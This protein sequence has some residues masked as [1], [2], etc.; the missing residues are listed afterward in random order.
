MRKIIFI[1]LYFSFGCALSLGQKDPIAIEHPE[2]LKLYCVGGENVWSK[3][4][5]REN[6]LLTQFTTGEDFEPDAEPFL[7]P[8]VI[9]SVYRQVKKNT[10]NVL[11]KSRGKSLNIKFFPKHCIRIKKEG[12]L[13][14]KEESPQLVCQVSYLDYTYKGCG[15]FSKEG[16]LRAVIKEE[17]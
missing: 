12:K 15:E 5:V 7:E 14:L 4:K 11:L 3:L 8:L 10:K 6:T 13:K 1:S 9:E 17:R 16:H 2:K